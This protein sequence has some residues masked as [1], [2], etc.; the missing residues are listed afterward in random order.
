[1]AFALLFCAGIQASAL[2]GI[3]LD[4]KAMTYTEARAPEIVDDIIFFTYQSET[5]ARHVAVRFA[6]EG[7]SILH[8]YARNE[9]GVFVL[10]YPVPEETSVLRYRIVVDGL[11]MRDPKNPSME[12]DRMGEEFS[13]LEIGRQDLF[14]ANPRM[15]KDGSALFTF[16]GSAGKDIALVGDFNNWDPFLDRLNETEDG[17]YEI[18]LRLRA[19]T[20]GYYFL[21]DGDRRLD[22]RNYET[23]ETGDGLVVSVFSWPPVRETAPTAVSRAKPSTGHH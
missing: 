22:P 7:F 11:W 8:S 3:Y 5:S 15:Q 14:K 21:I 12:T 10:D 20:H 2:D 23:M 17:V 6:H 16:R 4:L 19:G 18:S 13:V 9:Y 1:M